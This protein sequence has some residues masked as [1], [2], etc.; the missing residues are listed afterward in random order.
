MNKLPTRLL[1]KRRIRIQRPRCVLHCQVLRVLAVGAAALLAACG[2]ASEEPLVPSRHAP[3]IAQAVLASGGDP[4]D[5]AAPVEDPS[6]AAAGSMVDAPR[7]RAL[8]VNMANVSADILFDWA[9]RTFPALFPGHQPTL[10]AAPYLYRHYPATGI[11]L[12]TWNTSVYLMGGPYGAQPQRVGEVSAFWGQAVTRSPESRC[13]NLDLMFTV[14][15][16]VEVDWEQ[17]GDGVKPKGGESFEARGPSTWE[18]APAIEFWR[19]VQHT[20]AAGNQSGRQASIYLRRTGPDEVTWLGEV[21][22]ESD[23]VAGV[24][25]RSLINGTDSARPPRVD[26]YYGLAPGQSVTSSHGVSSRITRVGATPAET[27]TSVLETRHDVTTRVVARESIRVP[28]GVYETCRVEQTDAA[29]P[30]RVV[31]TWFAVGRGIPVQR[32]TMDKG[33][34]VLLQRATAVRVNQKRV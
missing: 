8:A 19:M 26:A 20:D 4:P 1:A 29:T 11:Y 7:R 24:G 30:G 12:G 27:R 3:G 28:A 13:W 34:A 21:Y 17:S 9:E 23:L 31:T 5:M 15:A 6:A 32:V 16:L 18:G 33:V 10:Y 25:F 2:G 22:M 14:G